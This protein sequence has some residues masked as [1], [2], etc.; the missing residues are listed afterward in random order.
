MS[1]TKLCN[2]LITGGSG[3]IGSQITFGYKPTSTTNDITFDKKWQNREKCRLC[4]SFN[5]QVFYNLNPTPPANHF[6]LSPTEQERIPLDIA[7]CKDCSHIQLVQIVDSKFLYSNYLYVSST[8]ITMTNHLKKSVLDFTKIL[9]LKKDDSILEIGANDGTC[10]QH[11]IENG[12]NNVVGVDP[13]KNIN[14]RHKLPII[15][16]FFSSS[17]IG[18]LSNKY[19]KFKLIYAFHCCAHIENIQ[20]VFFTIYNLLDDDGVFVMEVGYFY[21]VFKKNCFDTIYHEHIDYH[22]CIPIKEFSFKNGLLLFDVKTNTIQGGSIQLFF[23]KNKSIQVSQSVYDIITNEKQSLLHNYEIL[24]KWKLNIVNS[25]KDLNYILNGLKIYGKT[26]IGYGASAKSTTF[27]Y[28]CNLSNKLI[29]YI[30]DDNVYKQNYFSPGIH[31]PIFS[32]EKININLP[33]YI[34]ILSWNFTEEILKKIEIYR[35][36]GVRIIIPFPEIKII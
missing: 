19:S 31:I 15:C 3:M 25:T 32:I 2:A 26:I 9:N 17:M 12:Y 35:K 16:D 28:Q 10:I 23:S 14:N 20:D 5:L 4:D 33:D 30:I 24:S 34:I 7:I 36:V 18:L 22:T 8:S 21:E 27:L 29:D 13:A 1:D 6:V 11:L